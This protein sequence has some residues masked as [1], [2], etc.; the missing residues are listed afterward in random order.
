MQTC[1]HFIVLE[2]QYLMFE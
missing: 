1:P 2:V